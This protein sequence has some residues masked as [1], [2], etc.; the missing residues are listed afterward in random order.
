MQGNR[1]AAMLYEALQAQGSLPLQPPKG[2]RRG[3]RRARHG[4]SL[5]TATQDNGCFRGLAARPYRPCAGIWK[6]RTGGYPPQSPKMQKLPPIE[7]GAVAVLRPWLAGVSNGLPVCPLCQY[8]A[9]DRG[10]PCPV[11]FYCPYISGAKMRSTSRAMRRMPP[12]SH[13]SGV[14]WWQWAMV[15]RKSRLT[16]STAPPP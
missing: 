14:I 13:S 16:S 15:S 5:P 6:Y 9:P 1:Q 4:E 11:L 3:K 10:N 8:T 2:R 12:A 7:K